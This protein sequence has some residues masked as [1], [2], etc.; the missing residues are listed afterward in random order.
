MLEAIPPYEWTER[1]SCWHLVQCSTWCSYG[2]GI[3][4]SVPFLLFPLRVYMSCDV[5][6]PGELDVLLLPPAAPL[7]PPRPDAPLS[8]EP[9]HAVGVQGRSHKSTLDPVTLLQYAAWRPGPS[10]IRLL[11]ARRRAMHGGGV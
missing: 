8:L 4:Y 2:M 6:V 3:A 5:Q 9:Q 1:W 10:D 7:R 11:S